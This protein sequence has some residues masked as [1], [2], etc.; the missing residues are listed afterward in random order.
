MNEK[1]NCQSQLW[2]FVEL[3]SLVCD[4]WS[5]I[6]LTV[7]LLDFHTE[8]KGGSSHDDDMLYDDDLLTHIN[9][10]W[11]NQAKGENRPTTWIFAFSR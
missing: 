6:V 1:Q 5:A 3:S 10:G 2:L 9:C 4:I 11:R 7:G 8:K